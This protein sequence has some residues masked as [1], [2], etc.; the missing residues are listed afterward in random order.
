MDLKA[1]LA[2]LPDKPGCYLFRDRNGKIIYV[3][4]AVSLR[5]RVQS[6]FRASTLRSAAPKLRSLIHHTA[7]LDIMTVR[8]EAEALLTEGNLI[9]QYRP[10]FNVLLRDDKNYPALKAERGES[11]PRIVFSRIVREDGAEYF[12]PFPSDGV[13]RTALDFVQKRFGL[14]KCRPL[15]PDAETHRH[16]HDDVLRFCCAPCIGKVSAEEYKLRFEE[17]CAF[18]RGERLAI[19][20]EVKEQMQTA[21]QA[22]N[23]EKAAVLRDTW[24]ALNELV[25]RRARVVQQPEIVRSAAKHGMEELARVLAL[26]QTPSVLE[27]FDI[28]T[29]FGSY[30]V[31]SQVCS[32]DGVPD[33]RRYR[34]F[35]IKGFEGT[36]DPRAIAEVVGR[37]YREGLNPPDLIVIDG[38]ITQLR[39]ARQALAELGLSI[40][41]VGLAKRLEEIVTDDARGT[42]LLDRDSDA[43][44]VLM[45]LRDEAHRFAIGYNRSLRQKTLRNSVLDE[46]PGVGESKKTALLKKF[47]SVRRMSRA[48]VEQLC[49]VPGI[50]P[51]LARAI[52]IKTGGLKHEHGEDGTVAGGDVRDGT[53]AG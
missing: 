38:G 15:A 21:A 3:G 14:R 9:K 37:R 42:I 25:R 43:L 19:L 40:P 7:D 8:S 22:E 31:A 34:R 53:S 26:P 52:L 45:R 28:S 35:R 24:L 46:I 13:V 29:L 2:A 18:L 5:R 16:C 27:C 11:F 10:R 39:A 6:Y 48:S 47:G 50:T 33:K 44:K 1:K 51:E 23:F 17:A 36:D 4:K 49:G 12:G 20:Q 30:T 41:T 32:V